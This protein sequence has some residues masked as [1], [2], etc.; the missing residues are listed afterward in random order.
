[1]LEASSS[2]D[3]ADADELV[4]RGLR[5]HRAGHVVEAERHYLQALRLRG[6][7][8]DATHLLGVCRSQ[9]G[10]AQGALPLLERALAL[11]P[12]DAPARVNLGNAL[13]SCGRHEDA[14]ACFDRALEAL[15]GNADLLVNRG[16]VLGRM[17]RRD[18]ALRSYR[19]ALARAPG[20]LPALVGLGH[21]LR[22]MGDFAAALEC[23]REAAA[24]APGD[25]LAHF[26]LG[27]VHAD[28]DQTE[29]ALAAFETALA[30]H[31]NYEEALRNRALALARLGRSAE[32]LQS[33]DLAILA[34]PD[35]AM[36]HYS[37]GNLLRDLQRDA[38]AL[39]AFETALALDPALH[40][41]YV[42]R[43]LTLL[44]LERPLEA[45][46][47]LERALALHPDDA[48]TRTNRAIAMGELGRH[49][50]A[51][52]DLRFALERQ[53]QT[54]AAH[55]N[56]GIALHRLDRNQE[57]VD[58]FDRALAFDGSFFKAYANRGIVL[59]ET[60]RQ[61][62]ALADFQNALALEP[63]EALAK[64][65]LGICRMLLGDFRRGWR[66]MEARWHAQF[67][68]LKHAHDG[69]R[70]WLGDRDL[71]GCTA[72]LHAE[73]GLGDTLQFCRY[74]PLLRARGARVW[75]EVPP[76]V[77]RLM[78]TLDGVERLFV[79][80][81]APSSYDVHTPLMSLPLAL[82]TTPDTIPHDIPYLTAA[83][84][85]VERWAQVLGP[86]THRL[87]IGLAWSGNPTH[88]KDRHR[89]IPLEALLPLR[90]AGVEWIGLQ[91]QVRDRDRPHVD[92]MFERNV[93]SRLTDLAE[94]AAL[95]ANL[96]LVV[97]V[98]TSVAH[99]AGAL[100]KPVWIL[101]PFN[102]D[103]RWMLEREDSPWYP[104]ARLFRQKHLGD[105]DQV[106]ARVAQEVSR[107]PPRSA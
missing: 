13:Q 49:E 94:T 68:G 9:R 48:E 53:P 43:G 77:L 31:P 72:L 83:D 24:R 105:W 39:I 80:G 8:F 20:H 71:A 17:L 51:L 81:E 4:R 11:R 30:H 99:L 10:D 92:R 34:R 87:R 101:L 57:A 75:L 89:S 3:D 38:E 79:K 15:P 21:C 64:F 50:E 23:F 104:S 90:A 5:A 46:D 41:A 44:R 98:D 102:P 76:E 26:N 86:P 32:A 95:I 88:K 56:L 28:L 12:G 69:A 59:S 60:G 103:W 106:L 74:A 63:S 54:A 29:Q 1:M 35:G 55:N 84:Q 16:N 33:I 37:K 100:G 6:S 58:S 36:A 27:V 78:Q 85:D 2:R 62:L 107:L 97:S 25:P 42:N 65:N 7:H 47:S 91:T 61:S 45:L 93:E 73:Q 52:Q 82:G 66:D 14:L 19:A 70:L 22:E 96:D 67:P 40:D 18:E